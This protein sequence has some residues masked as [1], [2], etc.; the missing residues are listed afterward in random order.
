MALAHAIV[1][2]EAELER[3]REV[4]QGASRRSRRSSRAR[5]GV[6]KTALLEAVVADARGRAC[7]GRGRPPPRRRARTPRSTICSRPA[8]RPARRGCPRRSGA[9]SPPRCCSRTPPTRSTRAWSGSPLARCSTRCRAGAAR[10]RRLAVARRGQRGGPVVRA[11]PPRCRA[12]RSCSRR[13]ARRGG[14]GARGAPARPAERSR[15]G[16][17]ARAARTPPRSGASC[18]RGRARG[19]RRR[20]SRACTRRAAA[21]RC[22]ARAGPRARCRAGDRRAAAARAPLARAAAGQPRA[23]AVSRPLAEPSAERW[24]ARWTMRRGALGSRRRS[25]PTCSSATA[26]ACASATR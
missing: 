14:R 11:A 21:T 6:G 20:R 1:G 9:R 12:T 13:C 15:A 10:G 7:C 22:G 18:T 26:T 23:A 19:C 5:P 25:P 16:A 17:A 8:D 2:R 4:V 3:L 24:S